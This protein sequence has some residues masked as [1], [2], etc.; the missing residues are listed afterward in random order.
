MKLPEA[1]VDNNYL[2]EVTFYSTTELQDS[3]LDRVRGNVPVPTAAQVHF[4]AA[5]RMFD[6]PHLAGSLLKPVSSV[7]ETFTS[8]Q[9]R[10]LLKTWSCAV[11]ALHIS[12]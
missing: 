12:M 1:V 6:E 3:G 11:R 8:L 9:Y 4:I 7:L 10:F 5:F 2:I